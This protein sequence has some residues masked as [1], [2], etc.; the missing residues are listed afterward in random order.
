MA[1]THTDEIFNVYGALENLNKRMKIV[2]EKVPDYTADMLEVYRNLGALTK[3]IA[4][5]ENLI[6]E[7]RL[8]PFLYPNIEAER[9][10]AN[11]TQ[12]D[13]ANKLK[14]ERKSYYNWQTKGN[15]P[16]NILLSLADIFNCST[17]YLL[18][19]TN[20]PSCFIETIRN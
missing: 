16:I 19:R 7:V 6:K 12:E 4:E 2:E 17:D 8:V 15:I 3:R 18:G 14:I 5:L 11:M 1:N 10:R 20:N 13:L 9:A